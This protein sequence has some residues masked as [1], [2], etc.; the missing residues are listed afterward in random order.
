MRY[1]SLAFFLLDLF[2]F[3]FADAGKK[4]LFSH[5]AEASIFSHKCANGQTLIISLTGEMHAYTL[6]NYK[7]ISSSIISY[8]FFLS[9]FFV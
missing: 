8:S 3:M 4:N 6:E 1:F 9:L 7:D 5:Q 2:M